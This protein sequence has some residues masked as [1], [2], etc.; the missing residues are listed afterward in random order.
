[1]PGKMFAA[2]G[3]ARLQQAMHQV[4]RQHRNDLGVAVKSAVANHT[5]LAVVQIKNRGETQVHTT[6]SQ[7]SAKH[8]AASGGRFARL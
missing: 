1:M 4:L 8:K 3:H 2:I 7:F 5:A 6:S